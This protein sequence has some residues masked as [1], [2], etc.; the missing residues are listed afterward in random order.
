MRLRVREVSGP[1]EL[2]KELELD[3]ADTCCPET[4]LAKEWSDQIAF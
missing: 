2:I 3:S 4:F 1:M